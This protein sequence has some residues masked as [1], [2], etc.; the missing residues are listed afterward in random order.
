MLPPLTYLQEP[1]LYPKSGT[2]AHVPFEY[3]IN[4]WTDKIIWADR[5]KNKKELE[6]VKVER[7][8]LCT[9][10]RRQDRWMFVIWRRN[11]LPKHVIEG[12]IN[13]YIG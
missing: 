3:C 1:E 10:R 11:C 4:V 12:K 7:N 8:I 13:I 2:Y 6:R 9:I 5:V